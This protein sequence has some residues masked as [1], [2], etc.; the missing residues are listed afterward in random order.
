MIKCD[1]C[2]RFIS[3]SDLDSEVAIHWMT[4]PDSDLSSETWMTLCAEH[5]PNKKEAP[6]KECGQ[7]GFHKVPAIHRDLTM[8]GAGPRGRS[9]GAGGLWIRHRGGQAEAGRCCRASAGC[10]YL[11]G[12]LV[13][14]SPGPR[15]GWRGRPGG[16]RRPVGGPRGTFHHHVCLPSEWEGERCA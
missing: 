13:W 12:S 6:C 10:S 16:S 14:E 8:A 1:V 5:N 4:M 9:G 11:E 15:R 2:G 7:V 3:Y